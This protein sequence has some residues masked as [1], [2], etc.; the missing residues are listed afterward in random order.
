VGKYKLKAPTRWITPEARAKNDKK[1]ATFNPV[2][3]LVKYLDA[4]RERNKGDK[5][6]S[7]ILV[8]DAAPRCLGK[9]REAAKRD[10]K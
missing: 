2:Y 10:E 5:P 4:R 3:G 7:A 6:K 8:P 1:R 9:A